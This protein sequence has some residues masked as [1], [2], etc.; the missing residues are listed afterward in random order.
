MVFARPER[1]RVVE[2]D[3]GL[4]S[5]E[6]SDVVFVGSTTHIR[7]TVADGE[8]QIVLPNDGSAWV[9]APG[10]R[11]GVEFPADAIRLLDR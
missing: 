5:G 8:M 10:T 7:L 3:D 11:I 2:H 1:L 9:P 4:V 6:V